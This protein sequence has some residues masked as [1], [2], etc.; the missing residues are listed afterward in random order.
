MQVHFRAILVLALMLTVGKIACPTQAQERV[1]CDQCGRQTDD[2]VYCC[3]LITKEKT[4]K[5]PVWSEKTEYH[6]TVNPTVWA[7]FEALGYSLNLQMGRCAL[8]DHRTGHPE[9]D[10]LHALLQPGR[11]PMRRKLLVAEK[12]ETKSAV[13]CQPIIL[14]PACARQ[15]PPSGQSTSP[16]NPPLQDHSVFMP[17]AVFDNWSHKMTTTKE[18]R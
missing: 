16:A 17:P 9:G 10:R 8:S 1:S 4:V 11:P 15:R 3:N 18:F 14:C 2:F 5:K 6:C 12:E 13:E 7:F